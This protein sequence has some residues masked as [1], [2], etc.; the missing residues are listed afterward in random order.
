MS[1]STRTK[2]IRETE[3]D[4]D[5][6]MLKRGVKAV[7]LGVS[8]LGDKLGIGNDEKVP[9]KKEPERARFK[10]TMN[11][12]TEG[13]KTRME[14]LRDNVATGAKF[15]MDG[16]NDKKARKKASE[17]ADELQ[18]ETRGLKKGGS[19]SASKRAD[20]CAMKGKTR[21]RMV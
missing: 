2:K 9:P 19:V 3:P 16:V 12:P 15:E 21:G 10:T 11:Y 8:K 20:G 5:M 6:P 1:E 7:A 14:V 13:G 4:D 18:R 17:Y